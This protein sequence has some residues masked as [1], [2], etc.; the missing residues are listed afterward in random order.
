MEAYIGRSGA[1]LTKCRAGYYTLSTGECQK[2]PANTYNNILGAG[3]CKPC[4]LGST[5]FNTADKRLYI[6]QIKCV[7][8]PIVS[9][10]E[11]NRFV[12]SSSKQ[13]LYRSNFEEKGIEHFSRSSASSKQLQLAI[14]SDRSDAS[15]HSGFQIGEILL[16]A[17]QEPLSSSEIEDIEMTLLRRNIPLFVRGHYT[18]DGFHETSAVTAKN[19]PDSSMHARDATISKGDGLSLQQVDGTGFILSAAEDTEITFP[20]D[21]LPSDGKDFTL[22]AV[23]NAPVDSIQV[24]SVYSDATGGTTAFEY[25]RRCLAA[26]KGRSDW[27]STICS[28]SGLQSLT[29][30]VDGTDAQKRAMQA[31]G[32]RLQ[33]CEVEV[34]FEN[35]ETIV[36]CLR[37][38]CS[39]VRYK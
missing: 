29:I 17:R 19:W 33:I 31:A 24:K 28:K 10:E 35:T 14:N 34:T 39:A 37:Q 32:V 16:I 36:K 5:T 38:P 3:E 4:P 30:R 2:C 6:G 7:N 26:S 23:T 9:V 15:T 21:L 22:L 12:L 20:D 1:D 25:L 8:L 18:V 11:D 27:E 13:F